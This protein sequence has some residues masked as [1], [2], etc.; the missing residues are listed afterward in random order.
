MKNEVLDYE[1]QFVI[2][3]KELIKSCSRQLDETKFL[4]RMTYLFQ[5]IRNIDVS[6]KI[7]DITTSSKDE[8]IQKFPLEEN[9]YFTA[10]MISTYKETVLKKYLE[11]FQ[12]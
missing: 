12:K 8:L 5:Q 4:E 9:Q 6:R 3:A 11:V 10:E 7:H 2:T 1:A